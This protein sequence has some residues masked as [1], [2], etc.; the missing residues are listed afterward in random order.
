MATIEIDIDDYMGE[1]DTYDLI[2]EL[3]SRFKRSKKNKD[4]MDSF[5]DEVLSELSVEQLLG[6]VSNMN[7][8][9]LV[10]GMKLKEFLETGL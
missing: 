6:H 4:L 8:L 7:R 5:I 2:I 9:S 3:Q 1:I 10:Q